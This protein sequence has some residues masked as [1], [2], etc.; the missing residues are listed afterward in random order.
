MVPKR[1]ALACS[2]MCLTSWL[3][4]LASLL[5]TGG[6]Q[7]PGDIPALLPLCFTSPCGSG[8]SWCR[9]PAPPLC[10]ITS[11]L[12][13]CEHR[14]C[15]HCVAPIK[16]MC[17]CFHGVQSITVSCPLPFRISDLALSP[18]GPEHRP[19]PDFL[20]YSQPLFP[21]AFRDEAQSSEVRGPRSDSRME[22]RTRSSATQ[23]GTNTPYS[24]F[25][26]RPQTSLCRGMKRA[27]L[28]PQ[29]GP[30]SP[31]QVGPRGDG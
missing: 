7:T 10:P 17:S 23:P 24:F 9:F 31:R 20:P 6:G 19:P 5:T 26:S 14:C 4:C 30:S 12:R 27:M 3:A 11:S 28:R 25:C 22:F 1:T 2:E 15:A 29:K 16:P 21:T 13:V 18:H 8:S